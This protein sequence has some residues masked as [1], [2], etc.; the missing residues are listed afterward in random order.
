MLKNM[1]IFE[2]LHFFYSKTKIY[3]IY[4]QSGIEMLN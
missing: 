3:A 2:G 1:A 4:R